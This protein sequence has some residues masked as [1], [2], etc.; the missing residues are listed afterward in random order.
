MSFVLLF[1]VLFLVKTVNYILYH[2]VFTQVRSKTFCIILPTCVWLISV[3]KEKCMCMYEI[4]CKLCNVQKESA[5]VA[6]ASQEETSNKAD[7]NEAM[8]TEESE[9]TAVKNTEDVKEV[10]STE[11]EQKDKVSETAGNVKE[12]EDNVICNGGTTDV[13]DDDDDSDEVYTR[14]N[15]YMYIFHHN[16]VIDKNSLLIFIFYIVIFY[17]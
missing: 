15:I 2:R 11:E 9:A 6:S 3:R 16:I 10:N 14:S 13:N 1:S 12:S 4:L 8:V 7:V 5:V 17:N